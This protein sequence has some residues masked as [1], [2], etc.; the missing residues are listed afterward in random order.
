MLRFLVPV[1][2]NVPQSGNGRHLAYENAVNHAPKASYFT[3]EMLSLMGL[4]GPVICF[5][6]TFLA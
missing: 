6:V 2:E 4:V 5:S 3:I 1:T